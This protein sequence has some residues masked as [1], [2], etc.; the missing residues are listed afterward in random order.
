MNSLLAKIIAFSLLLNNG[1]AGTVTET[2]PPPE[3]TAQEITIEVPSSEEE[4]DTS[5]TEETV[6]E[7]P[8][9]DEQKDPFGHELSAISTRY[10]TGDTS[11][12]YNMQL[13]CDS[14]NGTILNPGDS[15][16]YNKTILEKSNNGKDYKVAGILVNG[17]TSTGVGGGICQISSTL[18]VSSLY[19]GMTITERHNHSAKIGYLKAGMDATVSWGGPDFKFRNDLEIP[20]KIEATMSGGLIT[21]RFLSENPFYKNIKIVVTGSNPSYTLTRYIDGKAEYVTKSTY[22]LPEEKPAEE[23]EQETQGNA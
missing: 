14:I 5:E 20:V 8:E 2:S 6:E 4:S 9:A 15:F 17:E 13:A 19:S 7:T 18:F 12:N 11:R 22:K 3:T 21:I 23:T 1:T 10:V 16:S